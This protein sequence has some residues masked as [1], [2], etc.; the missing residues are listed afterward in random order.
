MPTWRLAVDASVF[1]EVRVEERDIAECRDKPEDDPA[2]GLR[3][4]CATPAEEPQEDELT[5]QAQKSFTHMP[6]RNISHHL[7]RT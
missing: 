3:L 2:H 4:H 7:N 6:S 5:A 1:V